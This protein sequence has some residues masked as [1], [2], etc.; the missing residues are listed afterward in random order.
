MKTPL[1]PIK[2]PSRYGK[3]NS[4]VDLPK[5]MAFCTPDTNAALLALAAELKTKGGALILS[6]LFRSYEMQKQSHDDFVNGKKTAFSPPPGGSMHEGGRAMDLELGDLGMKLKDFWPLAAK[7]GF[8]PI[9]DKPDS[10]KSE[11]WHFDR[12][13]SHGLVYDYYNAEKADNMSSYKAMAVSAILA[14]DVRVDN[15]ASS[16]TE[17]SIQAGLIRLGFDPGNIDGQLGQRTFN[18]LTAAGIAAGDHKSMLG[19]IEKLLAKKFPA[20]F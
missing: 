6:D 4:L 1:K 8:F 9:I 2:I 7:H 15:F 14:I 18:A 12:R 16:A 17:A 11:A 13:G 3:N 20:E 10:G 19:E 5:R